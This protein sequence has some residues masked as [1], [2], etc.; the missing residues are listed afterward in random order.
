MTKPRTRRTKSAPVPAPEAPASAVVSTAA[1]DTLAEEREQSLRRQV[2]ALTQL[3]RELAFARDV[4]EAASRAKSEFLATVS[5]E[6][7]TPMQ[8]LV[9]TLDLLVGSS[10]GGEPGDLAETAQASSNALLAIVNDLVDFAANEPVQQLAEPVPFDLR[11]VVEDVAS[12]FAKRAGQRGVELVVQWADGA[13]SNVIGDGERVRTVLLQVVDNAVKFTE[14]GHV[15]I[16][17]DAAIATETDVLARISVEDTGCGIAPDRVPMLFSRHDASLHRTDGRAAD[18]G[19][20]VARQL[21][22]RMGGTI[23]ASSRLGEGSTFTVTF[24]LARDVE[25]V[26]R[27]ATT[28]LTNV[29]A[30]VVDDVSLHRMVMQRQMTGFGMRVETAPDGTTALQMA[31]EAAEAGDPFKLLLVDQNMPGM[32]G[33]QLGR[34]VRAEAGIARVAMMLFTATADRDEMKK[35]ARAGFDGYF[36]KPIRPSELEEAL[37]AVLTRRRGAPQLS[38]VPHAPART[39]GPRTHAG[40]R[41]LLVEDNAINQKVGR[42]LFEKLGCT[43]DVASNGLEALQRWGAQSYDVVFMDCDMP[44]MN[45]FDA[46]R[47][48]RRHEADTARRTPIVALTA[49]A[50]PSDRE[51]CLAAGMD[52][53]VAKPVREDALDA[54][55]GSVLGVAV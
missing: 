26:E 43:V 5:Q 48:I 31:R 4:A 35:F 50:L 36:L 47:E 6:I 45:G 15:L 55:L 17:V 28:P 41:V 54:M 11:H 30:L 38:L 22:E 13:P 51:R 7:R 53:F 44:V 9:G 12:R 52:D 34:A 19:L 21:A 16:A 32:T 20:H 29:H 46:T 14:R 40:R 2:E 1:A 39:A 8:G 24:K 3:N 49:N 23:I 18:S 42:R 33:E 27:A 10:L 25:G 37:T